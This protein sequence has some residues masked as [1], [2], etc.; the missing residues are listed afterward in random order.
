MSEIIKG[1]EDDGWTRRELLYA[2]GGML[3]GCSD[4]KEEPD[5]EELG[6]R[7]RESIR[8]GWDR[9]YEALSPGILRSPLEGTSL[10]YV[11]KIN[12]QAAAKGRL[13][14]CVDGKPKAFA[15]LSWDTPLVAACLKLPGQLDLVIDLDRKEAQVVVFYHRKVKFTLTNLGTGAG[16]V[17][18]DRRARSCLEHP[19][20]ELSMESLLYLNSSGIKGF[21]W[22]A[23]VDFP[24]AYRNVYKD[25]SLE[26]PEYYESIVRQDYGD[27]ALWITLGPLPEL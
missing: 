10:Q 8:Q 24:D 3:L 20:S 25:I 11:P 9:Q 5:A 15:R 12:S 21:V 19:D 18:C 26:N 27:V 16:V 1:G 13:V 22:R 23:S 4:K 7:V 14:H 17:L 6:R 2:A